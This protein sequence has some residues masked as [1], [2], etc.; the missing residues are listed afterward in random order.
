MTQE[1]GLVTTRTTR[2]AGIAKA[3]RTSRVVG[4]SCAFGRQ[5]I[6]DHDPVLQ[7]VGVLPLAVTHIN[8]YQPISTPINRGLVW[9][10]G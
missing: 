7:R 4:A 10:S 9:K 6:P 3:L 2:R 5:H 1:V 8:P